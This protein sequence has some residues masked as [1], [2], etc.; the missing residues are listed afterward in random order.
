VSADSAAQS[1][2]ES[3]EAFYTR[4][5]RRL[6]LLMVILAVV[7]TPVAWIRYQA[8]TGLSF[9]AGSLIAILNFYW[10]ALTVRAAGKKAESSGGR[11]GRASVMLRFLLRYVLIAFA[12]YAIFKGSADSLYGLFAGLSLPVVAILMEAVFE[13]YGSLR[14]GI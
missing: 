6:M 1:S 14:A 9:A 4:I 12:A 8:R 13:V 10:L 3:A 2:I 11:S 5:F 7:L